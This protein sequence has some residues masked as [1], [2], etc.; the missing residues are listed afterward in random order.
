MSSPTQGDHDTLGEARRA[1]RLCDHFED[2]WKAG[3]R[4]R[5]RLRSR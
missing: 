5:L 4:P 1:D 3:Q 2:A